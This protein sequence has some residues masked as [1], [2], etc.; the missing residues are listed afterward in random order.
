MKTFLSTSPPEF[1]A[2]GRTDEVEA[3]LNIVNNAEEF[4]YISLT[5]MIPA[6]R[7]GP[8]GPIFWPEIE[9]SLKIGNILQCSL[10]CI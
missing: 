4:I 2:P 8:Q 7:F 1:C 5:H 10:L 3:V 9:N 6:I